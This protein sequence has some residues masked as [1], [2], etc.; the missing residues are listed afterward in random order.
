M[1]EWMGG[2]MNGEIEGLTNDGLLGARMDRCMNRWVLCGW[3]FRWLNRWE[4]IWMYGQM[5]RHVDGETDEH[6][7]EVMN[8]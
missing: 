6:R 1:D 8:G 4:D 2:W 3:T 7:D 5:N